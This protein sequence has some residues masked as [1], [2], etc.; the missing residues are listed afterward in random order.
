MALK[1]V[2]KKDF[3]NS[4]TRVIRKRLM[5]S[6][7]RGRLRPAWSLF[8]L[9]VDSLEASPVR[10]KLAQMNLVKGLGISLRAVVFGPLDD[11]FPYG[12]ADLQAPQGVHFLPAVEPL[13]LVDDAL[14]QRV[15]FRSDL[16]MPDTDP[17]TLV[18]KGEFPRP[19][20][21]PA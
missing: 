3:Q 21:V 17:T 13:T 10:I 16:G 11:N 18:L 5:P 19:V 12:V 6:G 9:A 1:S 20:P 2:R 15:V 4:G 8:T 7:E 14:D